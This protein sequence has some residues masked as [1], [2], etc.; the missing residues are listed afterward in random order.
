VTT[1]AAPPR[2]RL[3][4][5]PV[6]LAATAV[7]LQVAY[8]L[9]S[10]TARDRL[11]VVTV[12]VFAAASVSHAAVHRGVRWAAAYTA[13]TTTLGLVAESVGTNTGVPFGEYDYAGSLGAK[14]LD[15]PLVVP[16]AWAMFAY[17]CLLVGQR[18]ARTRLGATVVG[19]WALASWDL[20][21]D[22]Q[23]VEAGHWTWRDVRLALPTAP[24]I[25]VS[26]YLGW[27][28]VAT[29]IV[30]VLQVLPRRDADDRVP[31][32]LFLWTYASS[33][34]AF[35]VFFGRP[36]V[37]LVGA[38]GMGLVAVPYARSLR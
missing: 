2:T 6:V 24:E 27:V 18:L 15:V 35:A 8:P 36:G 25:P 4:A 38:V 3:V 5:L 7:L 37:A 26:N 28:L 12:A 10:G 22:P 19:A 20:F 30:G 34:L 13:L 9:V 29:V 11:T 32:A 17:P 21:L 23:M 14:L 31:A 1:T 16:L 33:V